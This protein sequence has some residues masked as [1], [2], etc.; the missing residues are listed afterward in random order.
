MV[1]CDVPNLTGKAEPYKPGPQSAQSATARICRDRAAPAVP[2]CGGRQN[3]NNGEC[4]ANLARD[5]PRH[6]ISRG[7]FYEVRI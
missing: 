1:V 5:V 3:L 6:G 7:T 2:T 4:R